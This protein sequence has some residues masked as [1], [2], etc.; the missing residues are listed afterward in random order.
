MSLPKML[1]V[2]FLKV[3]NNLA[4]DVD[5]CPLRASFGVIAIV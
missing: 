5:L 4:R 2:P 1:S 3:P